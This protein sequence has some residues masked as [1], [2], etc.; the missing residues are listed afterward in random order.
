MLPGAPGETLQHDFDKIVSD[1]K[2]LDC[3][4]LRIGMMPLTFDGK[5]R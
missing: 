2:T 1:C 4:F 3:N 5:Q